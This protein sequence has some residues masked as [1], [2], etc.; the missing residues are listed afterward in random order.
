MDAVAVRA[1]QRLRDPEDTHLDVLARMVV[2]EATA[3][4][5]VD[6]AHPRWLAGQLATALEAIVRQDSARDLLAER[7]DRQLE[8]W[9]EEERS[10]G[11]WLPPEVDE[12][13]RTALSKP[14]VPSE[15]MVFRLIDHDILWS[16]M[17]ELL[18]GTLQRF[19]DRLRA[20]DQGLFGGIGR[21]AARRGRGLLGGVAETMAGQVVGAVKNE[22]EGRMDVLVAEFLSSAT[23]EGLRVVA[24]HVS[25]P[26]HAGDYGELRVSILDTLQDTEVKELAAEVEKLGV[27]D[28]V[29]ILLR[30]V[31]TEL[32][33][34]DFVDR[35]EQRVRTLLEEV[36]DGTL[37]AWLDE[38]GLRD[39]WADS[40]AEL[41]AQR[42]RAVTHTDRF[43]QWWETLFT[44]A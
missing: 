9:K 42:L 24:R 1:L 14:W 25:N 7:F 35:T 20:L 26:E 21:R 28:Y 4:P 32:D 27:M 41:V 8:S 5:I 15:E 40:T 31:R 3:T 22:V 23:R 44:S 10:L 17:R 19:R 2:D 6:I 18:E 34:P 38:V 12:P 30:A 16:L 33:D 39:V 13:L 11:T 37:G 29:D 36:G 43:E